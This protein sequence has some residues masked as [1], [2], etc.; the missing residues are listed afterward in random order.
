M[1]QYVYLIYECYMKFKLQPSQNW[2][3]RYTGNVRIKDPNLGTIFVVRLRN[4]CT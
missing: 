3:D 4:V 1:G 2:L